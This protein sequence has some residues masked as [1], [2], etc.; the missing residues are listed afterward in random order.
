[1]LG[2]HVGVV[3]STWTAAIVLRKPKLDSL[4]FGHS[5]VFKWHPVAHGPLPPPAPATSA[6]VPATNFLTKFLADKDKEHEISFGFDILAVV[7]ATAIAIPAAGALGTIS[8]VALTGA[9]ICTLLDGAYLTLR[10]FL[11]G[12]V[13]EKSASATAWDNDPL[14]GNLS[15][16]GLVL[17][18][19]DFFIN[20]A[21]TVKSIPKAVEALRGKPAALI[22]EAA[23]PGA[24]GAKLSAAASS[25]ES[26][27][28]ELAAQSRRGNALSRS[29]LMEA[30][31]MLGARAEKIAQAAEEAYKKGEAMQASLHAK[32][33]QEMLNETGKFIAEKGS[34]V[35]GS[36]A[37][38]GYGIHDNWDKLSW[39][40][41]HMMLG[42]ANSM[43]R[44]NM[45]P[46]SFITTVATSHQ[47]PV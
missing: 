10:Y 35:V 24:R 42:M 9:A 46:G 29:R 18:L 36:P 45:N 19:P 44:Y 28:A 25:L 41:R 40:G 27:A 39:A 32:I 4:G 6:A 30:S 26:R 47:S 31:S 8:L 38:I 21:A 13:E 22:A 11:G 37:A 7:V 15:I 20:G 5:A 2:P 33:I 43:Y 12:S 34:V 3:W 17:T 1:M 14:I 16:I 23:A